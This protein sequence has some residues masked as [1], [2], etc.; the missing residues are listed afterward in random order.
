MKTY[1]TTG[2]ETWSSC[3]ALLPAGYGNRRDHR[4]INLYLNGIYVGSTTWARTLAIAI[5]GYL[6]NRTVTRGSKI[7]AEYDRA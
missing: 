6:A 1:T 3:H 4:K 2:E 5:Q 7:E